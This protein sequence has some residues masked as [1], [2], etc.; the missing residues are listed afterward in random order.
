MAIRG[1]AAFVGSEDVRPWRAPPV[2]R[3]VSLL[4]FGLAIA[5]ELLARS[6]FGGPMMPPEVAGIPL[7]IVVTGL[8]LAWAAFGALI[9]WTAGSRIAAS[10]ALVFITLTSMLAIILGPALILI[11]QN[12]P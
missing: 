8:E 10:L 2:L 3:A 1:Q 5:L 4:P 6:Y 11:L 7:K 9:V 12:L